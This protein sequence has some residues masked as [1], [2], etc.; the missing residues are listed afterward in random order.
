MHL[1]LTVLL[2]VP[3]YCQYTNASEKGIPSWEG[4]GVGK[5]GKK[6]ISELP[7]AGWLGNCLNCDG[8]DE[9]D[10]HDTGR[11]VRVHTNSQC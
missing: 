2:R 11:S 3:I 4:L 5:V 6:R 7:P 8:C 9:Y 10:V 1:G